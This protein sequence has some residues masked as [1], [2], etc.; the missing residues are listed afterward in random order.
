MNKKCAEGY[1][2]FYIIPGV[3]KLIQIWS[4]YTILD[5]FVLITKYANKYA[6]YE[7]HCIKHGSLNN[8][9]DSDF[10]F[11]KVYIPVLALCRSSLIEAIK[12]KFFSS[13]YSHY[14][15]I[16]KVFIKEMQRQWDRGQEIIAQLNGIKQKMADEN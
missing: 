14:I 7:A 1:W 15:I 12:A 6:E 3:F 5:N 9:N 13:V 16:N 8:N 10:L 11:F 2:R 4:I